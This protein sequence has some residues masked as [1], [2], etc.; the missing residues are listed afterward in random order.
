VSDAVLAQGFIYRIDA[1]RTP[2][3]ITGRIPVGPADGSLDLEGIAARLEGGFWLASEGLVQGRS[4][5]VVRVD[6]AGAI[7]ETVQLPAAL[8]A[9]ATGSGFEG[10]AVTGTAAGGDETVWVAIQRG[11]ADD[12]AGLV[13]IGRYA[14]STKAWTFASYPLDP[15]SSPNGGWVGLSEITA[16][17]GGTFAIVERDN[18]IGLNARIKRIY[19]IAPTPTSFVPHGQPLPLLTKKLLRDVQADLDARSVSLPDKLEGLGITPEG[20]VFLATDNDGVDENYGE[21]L[22]FEVGRYTPRRGLR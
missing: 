6:D 14:V 19:E 1:S 2:A 12:A 7:L 22:F 17:P 5:A 15:V 9:S 13:K 21:T 20:R 3:V 4:N 18:Q 11:W 8:V 16:L 10:V